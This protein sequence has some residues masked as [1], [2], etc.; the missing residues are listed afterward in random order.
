MK[1]KVLYC[2]YSEGTIYQ[3]VRVYLEKD[4]SQAERDFDMLCRHASDCKTW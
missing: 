4:F 3:V 1:A 2:S